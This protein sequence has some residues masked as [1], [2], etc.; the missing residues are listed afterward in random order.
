V[1]SRKEQVLLCN[2]AGSLN[3]EHLH[4]KGR[5]HEVVSRV[6]CIRVKNWDVWEMEKE[7]IDEESD[8]KSYPLEL[9]INS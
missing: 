3:N 5:R 9:S 4:M 1:I 2:K 6:V 8:L 7:T